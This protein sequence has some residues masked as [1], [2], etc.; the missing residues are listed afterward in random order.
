MVETRVTAFAPPMRI[1]VTHWRN[2][3]AGDE[4]VTVQVSAT[5]V[6]SAME[7]LSQPWVQWMAYSPFRPWMDMMRA[8]WAP[9]AP[10]ESSL[11]AVTFERR[12]PAIKTDHF[13][14]LGP[15]AVLDADY[16]RV[17]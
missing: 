9:L 12:A 6:F 3:E 11:F 4:A 8:M 5:T 15:G 17:D 1:D 16:R 7:T 10:L 13:D 2:A 14:N